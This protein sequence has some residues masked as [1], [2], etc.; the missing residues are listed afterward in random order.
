MDFTSPVE[1]SCLPLVI[2]ILPLSDPVLSC[3]VLSYPALLPSTHLISPPHPH[4]HPPSPQ[5]TS[6]SSSPSS[7]SSFFKRKKP[8][9]SHHITPHHINTIL[10]HNTHTHTHTQTPKFPPPPRN[11][12]T[13]FPNNP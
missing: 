10:N 9:I 5:T 1:T 6:S 8:T 4:P 13:H 7:S 12:T 11:T 3:P 2:P